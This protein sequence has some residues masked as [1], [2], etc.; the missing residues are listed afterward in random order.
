MAV[1][2]G[3]SLTKRNKFILTRESGAEVLVVLGQVLLDDP[4]DE[5]SVE[6]REDWLVDSTHVTL[7]GQRNP[8]TVI[9]TVRKTDVLVVVKLPGELLDVG[10][11]NTGVGLLLGQLLPQGAVD[12]I[13]YV[14]TS[15]RWTCVVEILFLKRLR[16]EIFRQYLC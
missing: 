11:D 7:R 10:E 12:C 15:P 6:A 8:L 4:G 3:E 13:E 16:P 1:I 2:T 14:A 5:A 9:L